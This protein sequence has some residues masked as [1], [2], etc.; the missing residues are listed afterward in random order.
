M[1]TVDD[2]RTIDAGMSQHWRTLLD[3]QGLTLYT[4]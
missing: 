3:M 1:G 4:N 2:Y